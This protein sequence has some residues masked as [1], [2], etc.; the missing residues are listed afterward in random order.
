MVSPDASNGSLSRVNRY[1]AKHVSS[2]TNIVDRSGSADT[3]QAT[4]KFPGP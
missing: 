3:A 1:S 4:G 2:R